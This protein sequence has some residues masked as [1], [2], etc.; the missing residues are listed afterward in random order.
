MRR[1]QLPAG[2]LHCR[3]IVAR[4]SA[5]AACEAEGRAI[6]D[7]WTDDDRTTIEQAF[8]ASDLGSAG[9]TWTRA[10]STMDAYAQAWTELRTRACLETRVDRT[11]DGDEYDA[12]AE[13]LDEH[14]T[15]FATLID[16]WH[17]P[18]RRQIAAAASAANYLPPL[19]TCSD[20]ALLASS[21]G[22]LTIPSASNVLFI[23]PRP[24]CATE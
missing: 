2:E 7:D 4:R 9:E 22:S 6:A 1:L 16:T 10:E 20:A 3:S 24:P 5:R 15:T 11:R 23:D 12:M 17:E 21:F 13:C 14:R 8:L 19:S 18:E